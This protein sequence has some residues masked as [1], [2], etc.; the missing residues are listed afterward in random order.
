[1]SCFA[2]SKKKKKKSYKLAIPNMVQ[3]YRFTE[4]EIVE[5]SNRFKF[6]AK[7]YYN[8]P[9]F[10]NL[11]QFNEKISKIQFRENMGILGLETAFHLSDRIFYII[12]RNHDDGVSLSFL[13]NPDAFPHP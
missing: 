10:N 8:F 9:R 7:T 4:P 1:M 5:L 2:C 3:K 6:S 11:S 13:I 12:D